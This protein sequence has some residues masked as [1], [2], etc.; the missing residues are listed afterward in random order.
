MFWHHRKGCEVE[1]GIPAVFPRLWRYCLMLSASPDRADDLAQSVCLRALQKAQQYQPGTDL[2][3]WLFRI[4]K[5]MWFN[6]L[7]SDAIR[8]GGG[9]HSIEELDIPDRVDNNPEWN[10]INKDL[11]LG[12]LAL[13]EAQRMVVALVYI[14]GYSYKEAAE[15]L[16]SLIHI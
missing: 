15:L 6:E 5:N 10:M 4:A 14:E 13:P 11:L 2:D 12:V 8:Q 3:R 9:L 16:L 1:N 7:R